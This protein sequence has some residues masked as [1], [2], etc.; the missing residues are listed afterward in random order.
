MEESLRGLRLEKSSVM[1]NITGDV[2]RVEEEQ[3]HDLTKRTPED[4]QATATDSPKPGLS[5]LDTPFVGPFGGPISPE[6]IEVDHKITKPLGIKVNK[7]PSKSFLSFMEH[8][9]REVHADI[10]DIIAAN[11]QVS[12][13]DFYRLH[14]LE[15]ITQPAASDPDKKLFQLSERKK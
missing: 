7:L 1:S 5:R 14:G 2:G 15:T 9:S 10:L 4:S 8:S 12:C 6:V 11:C 13:F 3:E